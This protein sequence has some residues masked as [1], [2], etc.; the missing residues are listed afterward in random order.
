M[1]IQYNVTMKNLVDFNLY[2]V[3]HS[4]YFKV[5]F[6]MLMLLMPAIMGAFVLTMLAMG[7]LDLFSGVIAA[8]ASVSW[9][10]IYPGLFRK[11]LAK[12]VSRMFAEGKNSEVLTLHTLSIDNGKLIEETVHSKSE[13]EMS[14]I[15]RIVETPE[16]V[17]IYLS[18]VTAHVI[19]RKE[20]KDS[21]L[22]DEFVAELRK[23]I[24]CPQ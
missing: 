20:I 14:S 13:L 16:Y 10:F 7:G 1:K 12:S 19:P 23:E 3:K 8:F 6:A 22:L 5:R 21:R 4:K 15:E 24:P 9:L 18:A 17:F 11:G 2:H